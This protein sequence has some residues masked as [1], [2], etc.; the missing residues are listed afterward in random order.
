M[1]AT[2][3]CDALAFPPFRA[4]LATASSGQ[5]RNPDPT[6]FGREACPTPVPIGLT[7]ELFG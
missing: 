2:D 3:L 5:T 7:Q 4:H 1:I 6:T